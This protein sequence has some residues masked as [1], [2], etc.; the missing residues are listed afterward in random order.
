MVRSGWSLAKASSGPPPRGNLADWVQSPHSALFTPSPSPFTSGHDL[1]SC[2]SLPEA[3]YTVPLLDGCPTVPG[4]VVSNRDSLWV[5][6]FVSVREIRKRCKLGR[7][8]LRQHATS[9]QTQLRNTIL[10][11]LSVGTGSVLRAV[12]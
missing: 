6:S 5:S 4:A 9:V 11:R 8:Q 1:G 12:K 7:A 3:Q 2:L 10:P